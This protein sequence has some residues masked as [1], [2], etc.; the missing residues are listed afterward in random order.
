M[1]TVFATIALTLGVMR[2]AMFI[3]LHLVPS[4]YN[5][6]EHAVSDYAVGRTRVLSSIMTWTTAAFW[7]ALA[8]AVT[9]GFPN[10][11]DLA[12][13]TACLLALA[14]IF[15]VLPFFPA[16]LEGS[17]P[18]TKG[19]VHLLAAVVWFALGYA[20]MGNFI[21][22]LVPLVP[23]ALGSTL[24]I[25]SWVALIALVGLVAA[26]LIRPLRRY[27]FGISER[28]FLLAASIFY[29][30]VAIGVTCVAVVA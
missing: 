20:C 23:D 24:V 29:V 5:I 3:A 1:T 28:I 2:L 27:A 26:L 8:I 15:I 9:T 21:R 6:V 30:A 7:A 19:R 25:A 13:I 14:V 22:L 17:K 10:W 12:G 11:S 18:T 16:D 4:D